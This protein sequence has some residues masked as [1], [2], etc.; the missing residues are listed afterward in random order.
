MTHARLT[1][2]GFLTAVPGPEIERR[3][4]PGRKRRALVLTDEGAHHPFRA[5]LPAHVT[6]P[7][8]PPS[9]PAPTAASLWRLTGEDV[10]GFASVYFATF[11]AVLVFI[12]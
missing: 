1:A 10:R 9:D 8:P 12:L 2:Q 3:R 7:A 4:L 6:A 5:S 11:A